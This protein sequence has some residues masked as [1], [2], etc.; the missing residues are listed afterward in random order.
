MRRPC[1]G[2]RTPAGAAGR[3][4]PTGAPG[5]R[6]ARA[7]RAWRPR[8]CPRPASRRSRG[9]AHPRRPARPRTRTRCADP[10]HRRS[11]VCAPCGPLWPSG[12]ALGSGRERSQQG[13]P[14]PRRRRQHDLRGDVGPGRPHRFG[15]PRAGLPRR[16]RAGARRRGGVRRHAGRTQPVPARSRRP[17]AGR[18]SHP[19]PAAPLRARPRCGERRRHDRRHRGDRRRD[20]R[21]GR[22]R[23]RGRG[24]GALLRQLPRDD[25][26]RRRRTTPGDPACSRLPLRR[27]PTSRTR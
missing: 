9:P 26:V 4:G 16:Q 15:Q 3:P 14:A 11:P 2:G 17:R 10:G 22:P 12:E 19:A 8:W 21:A 27:R 18:G 6:S 23:R 13:S 1:P 7:A 24:V 5:S 20:A 25:P